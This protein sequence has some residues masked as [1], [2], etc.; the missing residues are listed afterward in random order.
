MVKWSKKSIKVQFSGTI[1]VVSHV[2]QTVIRWSKDFW[3]WSAQLLVIV[4]SC[5]S[6]WTSFELVC[7]SCIELREFNF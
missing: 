3:S 6:F 2:G 5:F 7:V 4:T 1:G